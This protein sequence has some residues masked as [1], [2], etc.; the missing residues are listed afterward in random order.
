MDV[1]SWP[2]LLTVLALLFLIWLRVTKPQP[3]TDRS[4][5]NPTPTGPPV[6]DPNLEN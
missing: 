2:F 6:D 5:L 3:P 4:G 1:F